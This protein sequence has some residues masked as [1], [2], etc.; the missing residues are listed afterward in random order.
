MICASQLQSALSLST[1]LNFLAGRLNIVRDEQVVR[2]DDEELGSVSAEP[3]LDMI[4]G[5]SKLKRHFFRTMRA[6]SRRFAA[7]R[8]P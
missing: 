4:K 6:W 8:D 1:L 2:E 3:L 7:S 5:G